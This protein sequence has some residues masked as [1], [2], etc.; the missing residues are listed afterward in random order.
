MEG[1]GHGVI[2]IMWLH[3]REGTDETWDKLVDWPGFEMDTA[4]PREPT[5]KYKRYTA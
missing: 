3:L 5:F 1:Y 4:L 2:Q